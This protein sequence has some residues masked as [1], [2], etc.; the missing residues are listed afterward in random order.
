MNLTFGHILFLTGEYIE[1]CID[2]KPLNQYLMRL[3]DF[4]AFAPL[5]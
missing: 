2:I 3:G 1:V 5:P 4:S